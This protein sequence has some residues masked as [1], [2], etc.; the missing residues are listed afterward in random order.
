MSVVLSTNISEINSNF[1]IFKFDKFSSSILNIYVSTRRFFSKLLGII[2][3]TVLTIILSPLIIIF[4]LIANYVFYRLNNACAQLKTDIID[5]VKTL[6]FQ[7]TKELEILIISLVTKLNPMKKS[8]YSLRK[9][10][11]F[12]KL[13]TSVNN[14]VSILN[15]TILVIRSEYNFSSSEI[16]EDSKIAAIAFWAQYKKQNEAAYQQIKNDCSNEQLIFDKKRKE[17]VANQAR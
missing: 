14:S 1:Q 10:F 11:L 5:Q 8:L 17:Y 15:E 7:E 3:T 12:K 16:S 9:E 13:Y 6:S 4:I 2:G